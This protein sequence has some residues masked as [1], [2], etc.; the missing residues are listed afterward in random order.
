M[1]KVSIL[2]Q[3]KEQK[4]TFLSSAIPTTKYTLEKLSNHN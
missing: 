3:A 1:L 2:N 4:E